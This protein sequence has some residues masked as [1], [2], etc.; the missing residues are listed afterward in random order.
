MFQLIVIKSLISHSFSEARLEIRYPY[1]MM[2]AGEGSFLWKE[3][4]ECLC[5]NRK[6]HATIALPF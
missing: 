1:L 6:D 3:F 4:M 2:K 5:H